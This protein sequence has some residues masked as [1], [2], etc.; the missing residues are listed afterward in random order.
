[1]PQM[2][3]SIAR[4]E[5]L[6]VASSEPLGVDS[7]CISVFLETWK[8]KAYTVFAAVPAR[9]AGYLI[10]LGVG[11]TEVGI[12]LWPAAIFHGILALLLGWVLLRSPAQ[13]L[14]G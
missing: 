3:A 11:A 4:R 5:T 14:R 13:T 1:M 12:M 9:P 8:L 6:R 2:T 7:V 10:F